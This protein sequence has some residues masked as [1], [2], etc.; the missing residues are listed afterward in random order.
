[1]GSVT[2]SWGWLDPGPDPG[3]TPVPVIPFL[4]LVTFLMI[5]VI[6]A[7]PM[8]HPPCQVLLGTGWRNPPPSLGVAAK[9]EFLGPRLQSEIYKDFKLRLQLD[10]FLR[11]KGG[12]QTS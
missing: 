11:G 4:L 10:E 12:A 3:P 7:S 2:L 6:L 5:S 9:I 1:M 8:I